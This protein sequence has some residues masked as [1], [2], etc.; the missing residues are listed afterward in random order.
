MG[1]ECGFVVASLFNLNLPVATTSVTIGEHHDFLKRVDTLVSARYEVRALFGYG[2]P[3]LI[4][5]AKA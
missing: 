4:I 2:F 5:D 1:R 3:F